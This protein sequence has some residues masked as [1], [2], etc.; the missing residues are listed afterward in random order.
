MLVVTAPD[1]WPLWVSAVAAGRT[2]DI[3][4]LRADEYMVPVLS[5]WTAD[6]RKVLADLGYVGE[7]DLLITATKT[8]ADGTLTDEQKQANKAHN[9]VRCLGERGNA[10]LKGFKALRRV[11]LCPWRIGAIVAAA[12]VLLHHRHARTT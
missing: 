8:P 7:P 4:M 5:Q 6:D 10:L 9:R 11:S 1:G 12:L 2:H 3:T